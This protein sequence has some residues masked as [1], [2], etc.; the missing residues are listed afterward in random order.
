MSDTLTNG[1][2][3]VVDPNENPNIKLLREKANKVDESTRALADAQREIAVLKSG[4]DAE[5]PIGK[6]FLKAYDGDLADS[7]ALIA[8]AKEIGVPMKGETPA[9]PVVAVTPTLDPNGTE[10][11]QQLAAEAPAD[12]GESV[13]PNKTAMDAFEAAIKA[14]KSSEAARGDYLSALAEAAVAG[15]KRVLAE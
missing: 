5:S 2:T 14:G 15:D 1:E 6:M 4:I 9:E 13:D 10:I 8:A 7:E 12:T 3:E 11:R